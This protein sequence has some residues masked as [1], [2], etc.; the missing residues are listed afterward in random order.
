MYLQKEYTIHLTVVS[1]APE[2]PSGVSHIVKTQS[3]PQMIYMLIVWFV[4][5]TN[6]SDLLCLS[7]GELQF[8]GSGAL[9]E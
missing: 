4:F 2:S 8:C 9:S 7:Q 1:H 6:I 5:L 3:S